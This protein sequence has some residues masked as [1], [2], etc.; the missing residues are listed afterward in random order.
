MGLFK[1]FMI[2]VAEAAEAGVN[3][4][5]QQALAA[6]LSDSVSKRLLETYTPAQWMTEGSVILRLVGL[7]TANTGVFPAFGG[8]AMVQDGVLFFCPMERNGEPQMDDNHK[9][10]WIEVSDPA[11]GFLDAVNAYFKTDFKAS[12]FDRRR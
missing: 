1:S 11:T 2:D 12:D 5:D 6:R 8:Y 4:L 7:A 10:D 9:I 3:V